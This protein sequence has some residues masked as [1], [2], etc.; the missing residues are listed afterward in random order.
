MINPCRLRVLAN[1]TCP[2]NVVHMILGMPMVYLHDNCFN[3]YPT[4]F[5]YS[6]GS[7][8]CCPQPIFH[9][10]VSYQQL[11]KLSGYIILCRVYLYILVVDDSAGKP[12]ESD[13]IIN[14]EFKMLN[15]VLT[16]SW[17]YPTEF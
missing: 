10:D 1:S 7:Q 16:L 15:A 4:P 12:H 13:M 17:F 5:E 2:T 9:P 14:I 3:C 11:G 6:L 8:T